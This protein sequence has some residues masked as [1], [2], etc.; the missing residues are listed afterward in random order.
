MEGTFKLGQWIRDQRQKKSIHT[1]E[2]RERLNEIG[3]IWNVN[4]VRGTKYR[5]TPVQ[6]IVAFDLAYH[7]N[8]MTPEMRTR[9][10]QLR[11]KILELP[12]VEELSNQRSWITYQ[13]TKR[14]V[15]LSFKQ[16]WIRILLRDSKYVEDT[17]GM[18]SDISGNLKGWAGEAKFKLDGDLEYYFRLIRASYNSTL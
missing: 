2:R 11:D 3:F 15:C 14:F 8:R 18:V 1:V 16:K 17:W 5:E 12:S 13:T 7:L 6:N 9:A 4:Q 10:I